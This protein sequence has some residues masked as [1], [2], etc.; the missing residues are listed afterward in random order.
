[1]RE[2]RDSDGEITTIIKDVP[3]NTAN[4]FAIPGDINRTFTC[5]S[6]VDY[7][8]DETGKPLVD[9]PQLQVS[10]V[11]IRNSFKEKGEIR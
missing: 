6:L 10:P 11:D 5:S 7:V 9:K 8:Y 4:V 3:Y 1:M 2:I